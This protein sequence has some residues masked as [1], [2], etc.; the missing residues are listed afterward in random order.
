MDLILQLHRLCE[1]N[2]WFIVFGGIS[3]YAA[4]FFIK[5][6]DLY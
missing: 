2:Q 3:S 5:G 6:I 4:V 1:S